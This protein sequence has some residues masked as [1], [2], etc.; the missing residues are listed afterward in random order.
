MHSIQSAI[1]TPDDAELYYAIFLIVHDSSWTSASLVVLC[2]SLSFP[3][4]CGWDN[5]HRIGVALLNPQIYMNIN[6][7]KFSLTK[8]MNFSLFEW[9]YHAHK[10]ITHKLIHSIFHSL[11]KSKGAFVVPPTA[12]SEW[13]KLKVAAAWTWREDEDDFCI[14][15]R[16]RVQWPR[17]R[18]KLVGKDAAYGSRENVRDDDGDI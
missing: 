4:V 16:S 14:K 7:L 2:H 3:V 11:S 8:E 17:W 13:K 6:F 5:I 1:S 12:V 18:S 15:M 9:H 10:E